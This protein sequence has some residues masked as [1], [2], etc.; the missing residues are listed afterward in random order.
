MNPDR[1]LPAGIRSRL[2]LLIA[3]VLL[4]LSL[5]LGWIYHQRYQEGRAQVLQTELEVAQGIA[6]TFAA[7]IDDVRRLNYAV[8][9]AILT[10]T[11][12]SEAKSFRLLATASAPYE[13]VRNLSWVDL[14]GTILAS[15]D[16]GLIG[17]DLSTRPYFQQFIAGTHWAIGDLT[18][19]GVAATVPTFA[20]AVA[21][22]D[23][24]GETRGVLVAGIDPTLLGALTF[25][26]RRPGGGAFTIFD[27]QGTVVYR[28]P[29][30]PLSWEDRVDWQKSDPVLQSALATGVAQSGI[31][32]L[33][34]P[35]GRW[36][37]A[38]VP[39]GNFGWVAGAGHP[40]PTARTV[41]RD[42]LLP[43]ASLVLLTVLLAFI[44]AYLLARNIAGSL[45]RLEQDT[46]ALG[47]GRLASRDDT[48]APTE[49]RRLR[50]TVATM[51]EDLVRRAEDLQESEEALRVILDSTYD[52]ILLHA[53]DGA[54][55]EVNQTFERMYGISREQALAL[56]IADL[57]AAD[58]PLDTTPALWQ[59]VMDGQEQLFE[60]RA[61][62]PLTGAEFDVEV[63]LRRIR[64]RG[65][66]I[67]LANIRDVTLRKQTQ[68]NLQSAKEWAEAA[69]RAKSDFLANMSHEL[70]T[71][72]TVIMGYIQILLESGP[73][74]EQ[75]S[76]L[77]VVDSAARRLLA[78]IEDVLDIS[79]IEARRLRIEERP[80]GLR[81][82][83]RQAAELFAV[84]VR[85]KGLELRWEVAEQLADKVHGDPDRLMQVLVNLIGNAVKFTESGAVTVVVTTAEEGLLFS[86]TDTGIGIPEDALDQIFSPFTQVDSSRT[87]AH[88]GTGLGLTICR[89]LVELMGGRI[90]AE[91][92]KG[93]GSRFLF[94][95]PLPAVQEATRPDLS[96]PPQAAA[97][98]H[99]L[100]VEDDPMIRDMIALLL[101]QRG[102]R[103]ATAQTGGEA[104][105]KWQQNSFD[106]V[107]M[108]VQMRGMDGLEATGRIRELEKT[109]GGHTCIIGLT[110]QVGT[111]FREQCLAAGMDGYLAKPVRREALYEAVEAALKAKT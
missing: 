32:Q 110:A 100:L 24:D 23:D 27:R 76:M 95:L 17:R 25:T 46:R 34:V 49:V 40:E 96:L 98:G 88:G 73:S 105:A 6:T 57:S 60:W 36:I 52:G 75:R 104:V 77:E 93:R 69:N 81:E 48:Q 47:S 83:V 92:D 62:R 28:S 56:T 78:I 7:F 101:K 90:W 85:E 97:G 50:A 94:T 58:M 2:F 91:S 66:I 68:K 15:S 35:G 19:T 55:L 9:Q 26:Q 42:S 99:I 82:V 106:L 108:D 30:L 64:R 51:A 63:F 3:L 72:M 44:L 65:R 79:R 20:V 87:R 39:I 13:A 59:A 38:R 14:D 33:S 84:Q 37:S 111:N 29:E 43:D 16:A 22:Q 18:P 109:R 21:I 41:V 8:G 74:A 67:I 107:L 5:L 80:F 71:P 45:L 102:W 4:P 1:I 10:F 12:Y 11:P 86:V 89:E 54:I 70:R 61:R 53:P 103:T 31:V